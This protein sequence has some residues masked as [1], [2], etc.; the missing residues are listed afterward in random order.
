MWPY[1]SQVITLTV[2][3]TVCDTSRPEKSN[4]TPNQVVLTKAIKCSGVEK[5]C[6]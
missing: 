3:L 6:E 1:V 4:W 5:E 2:E